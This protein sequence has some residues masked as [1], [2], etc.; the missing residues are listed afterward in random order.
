MLRSHEI[1]MTKLESRPGT[2]QTLGGDVL[3]GCRPPTAERPCRPPCWS[4]DQDH[5]L[6]QGAGLLPERRSGRPPCRPSWWQLM[7]GIPFLASRLLCSALLPRDAAQSCSP[8]QVLNRP[9]PSSLV[10]PGILRG[11]LSTHHQAIF[12]SQGSS[13]AACRAFLSF[14]FYSNDMV[15]SLDFSQTKGCHSG[16]RAPLSDPV[17][18]LATG[19]IPPGH[20]VRFSCR[21][22]ALPPKT[23]TLAILPGPGPVLP[24]PVIPR[25][26]PFP[27]D[28]RRAC[29]LC[30]CQDDRLGHAGA[31]GPALE[32][33]RHQL[34]Q[35][36]E[37]VGCRA[38]SSVA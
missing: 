21:R 11:C 5:P 18:F 20:Q 10:G 28:K 35:V 13:F 1:N 14:H 6:H 34:V 36:I 23:P 29:R 15:I 3:P 27:P 16:A 8:F 19:R 9:P 25:R 22:P 31:P 33:A 4:S 26:S 30:P 12:P 37:V 2:G 38:P 17:S 7:E 24:T 32:L